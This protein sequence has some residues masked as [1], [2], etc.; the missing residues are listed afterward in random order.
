MQEHTLTTPRTARYFT[1]GSLEEARELWIV[2]HG[3]GQ[4]ASRFLER[5]RPIA[6]D[7]RCVVAPE[8]L[9]RFYL[10]EN[11][12]ER[13]VGASWMTKEDRLHE[14]DDYVRYLDALYDQVATGREKVTALGFSQGSATACRWTVLGAGGGE[15]GAARID[16]LIVWGGEVPPDPDLGERRAAER[17]RNARLTLVYGNRDEFFTPKIVAATEARLRDH[18][19]PYELV[20]FEGGHEIHPATLQKLV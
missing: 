11:P 19:I 1:I 4:L 20:P 5:F 16:R 3:Y 18:G 9:S 7:H 2:C 6:D 17:L 12:A 8:G 13:R 14:I 10:T 15:G